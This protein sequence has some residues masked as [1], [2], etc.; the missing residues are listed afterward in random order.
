V[1]AHRDE[2]LSLTGGQRDILIGEQKRIRETNRTIHETKRVDEH[3]AFA[4]LTA[5]FEATLQRE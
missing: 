2:L 1:A 3:I 4:L 5:A